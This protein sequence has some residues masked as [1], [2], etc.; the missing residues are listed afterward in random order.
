MYNKAKKTKTET[1]N[2]ITHIKKHHES[3]QISKMEMHK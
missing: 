1:G 2:I 3:S